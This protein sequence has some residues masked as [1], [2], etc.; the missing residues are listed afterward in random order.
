MLK[1]R[2]H[3]IRQDMAQLLS[4]GPSSIRDISQAVGIMEKDVIEHLMSVE[5][6][7]RSQHKKLRIEPYRCMNCGFVFKNR[8]KYNKPGKCPGCKNGRI[9]SALFWVE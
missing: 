4:E 7:L 6:S 1:D 3:T 5:K 9:E 2:K 8:K